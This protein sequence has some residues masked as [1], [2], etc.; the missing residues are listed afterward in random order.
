MSQKCVALFVLGLVL[1][2]ARPVGAVLVYPQSASLTFQVG[3]WD[4]FTAQI[5]DGNPFMIDVNPTTGAFSLPASIYQ[6]NG[7]AYS[8]PASLAPLGPAT[9]SGVNG[10][11]NFG[12]SWVPYAG[13]GPGCPTG[14]NGNA[15]VPGGGFGGLMPLLIQAHV[16]MGAPTVTVPTPGMSPVMFLPFSML[17]DYSNN[18]SFS[19]GPTL[20][21]GNGWTVGQARLIDNTATNSFSNTQLLTITGHFWDG[22][23]VLAPNSTLSL[24]TVG[25]IRQSG[26]NVPVTARL[27]IVMV[28][29]PGTVLLLGAGLIGLVVARRKFV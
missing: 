1:S 5:N 19:T 6:A 23:S 24:V 12:P 14:A 8:L 18:V 9:L 29:E 15:C 25:F 2:V 28:P 13:A 4:P 16:Y 22:T 17:G 7:D 10:A 27:T 11:G 3:S 26:V 20:A 21:W